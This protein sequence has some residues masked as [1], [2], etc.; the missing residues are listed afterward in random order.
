MNLNQKVSELEQAIR[1][2]M[3]GPSVD[4]AASLVTLENHIK[5]QGEAHSALHALVVALR[6]QQEEDK[7]NL[8]Q[9]LREV[10]RRLEA[11]ERFEAERQMA[12]GEEKAPE[13]KPKRSLIKDILFPFGKES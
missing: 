7:V 1:G 3:G 10:E 11:L 4:W 5:E 9:K 12:E 2:I 6:E 8:N 13:A